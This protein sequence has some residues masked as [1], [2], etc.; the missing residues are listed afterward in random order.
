MDPG[1]D[2]KKMLLKQSSFRGGEPSFF[3]FFFFFFFWC[4]LSNP[5]F[6]YMLEK[7]SLPGATSPGCAGWDVFHFPHY[8]TDLMNVLHFELLI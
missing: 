3:F 2:M 4:C 8:L 6:S 1:P 7:C 5:G